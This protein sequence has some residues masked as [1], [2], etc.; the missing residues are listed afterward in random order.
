MIIH[1][2]LTGSI[3][4]PEGSKLSET[5]NAIILPNGDWLKPFEVWELNDLDDL[6]YDR[7]AER[8]CYSELSDKE[9]GYEP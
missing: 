6:T 3:E 7:L 1:Y 4:V 9:L 8:D 2:T 5:E